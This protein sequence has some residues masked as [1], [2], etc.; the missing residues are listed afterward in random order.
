MFAKAAK[1]YLYDNMAIKEKISTPTTAGNLRPHRPDDTKNKRSVWSI[2][3]AIGE[4]EDYYYDHEAI[5]EPSVSVADKRIGKGRIDYDAKE[6][7]KRRGKKGGGQESFV[8]VSET[9][10]KRSVWTVTTKGFPDAHFATFPE[11]LIEPM[12]KAGCPEGGIILDP[13]FKAGT[14][15]VVAAKHNRDWIGIELNP[16]YVAIARKR[17]AGGKDKRP[18]R[19]SKRGSR[20]QREASWASLAAYL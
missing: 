14:T 12:V 17:I 19:P 20:V 4:C 1:R 6:T 18:Q 3:Q 11:A 10:N 9:R 13:F 2:R 16:E 7:S 8:S 5:K 15:G